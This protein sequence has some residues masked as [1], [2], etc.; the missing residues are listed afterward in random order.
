MSLIVEASVDERGVEVALEVAKGET[1]ALLGPNGA[2]KS[3]VL[4][5]L[6]GHLVPDRGRVVLD[7]RVLTSQGRPGER[8]TQIPPHDRRVS[9]LAQEP[10]LF[11]H[12][13]V[14]DNVAFGPRSTGA[15]RAAARETARQWLEEVGVADL[16]GRRPAEIS[17]G[18]AQRAAVARALAATPSLMLLDE[19]MAALDVDVAPQLRQT[20]RRVLADRTVLLVTHDVLD[21]L[22]LA[23]R[24]V[25]L[26][27]GAVVEHGPCAEVLSRPRSSFAARIAGLNMLRGAWR[28]GA[29]EVAYGG[30]SMRVEGIA[31]DPV[32]GEGEEAVAVFGPSAVSVF[33]EAP[34]GSPRNAVEVTLSDLEPHGGQVRVRAGTLSADVSVR[35][36]SEL[37]LA[38]GTRGYFVV[39][40]S[41]VAIYRTR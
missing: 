31:A 9:L 28:D 19:P 18:Q 13:S 33:L 32:P 39:K 40:A 20:L 15:G 26:E 35:A 4:S 5:V 24:V 10:L 23:D 38:P 14:L 29:V 2:G 16:A 21:A 22:L 6:A 34:H 1:V 27:D 36:V 8:R 12:L 7:G 37:D 41:E 17:G 30:R 11:P 3:T 25:V